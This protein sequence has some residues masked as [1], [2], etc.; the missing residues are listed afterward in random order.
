M[1]NFI[2]KP[3]KNLRAGVKTE[4]EKNNYSLNFTNKY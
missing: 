1:R 4:F 2:I 3:Y